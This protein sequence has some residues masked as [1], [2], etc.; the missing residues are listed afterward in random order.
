MS[1]SKNLYINFWIAKSKSRN[2]QCPIYA[3]ITI[4]G[5]RAELST[6]MIITEELWNA[7]SGRATG[8]SSLAKELNKRLA[9]IESRLYRCYDDLRYEGKFLSAPNL[10]SRYLGKDESEQTIKSIFAYHKVKMKGVLA[11]GT[12][13]N[14]GATENYVLNFLYKS[15]HIHNIELRALESRF[16]IDFEHFLHQQPSLTNNG[17]MKHLE[18]FKKLIKLAYELDWLDKNIFKHH[19]LKF[20]K[21]EKEFLTQV[22][23]QKIIDLKPKRNTLEITR[24]IFLFSCYTSLSYADVK[25]MRKSNIIYSSDGEKW[26][27]SK[28]AKTGIPLNIPL[29]P[30]P[31]KI[32]E[33]Y[34]NHPKVTDSDFL[35]P[36]YSNQK[37]NS[38]LREIALKAE[39]DKKFTFHTARHTFATTVTL[40]NGVPI[41]TVSKLLGHTKLA[42]TQIY[43]RVLK[44]KIAQDMKNLESR[45]K[46]N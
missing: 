38:Y 3:R 30:I 35:L 18:R 42:T 32:L 33:K 17:V 2:G 29:L 31:Q 20:K 25:D 6:Q 44:R 41:E 26:I 1:T 10:K 15:Q 28:R 9:Q 37:I 27:K 40:S 46:S 19:K 5:K 45:L 43:A 39:I 14:Y 36:V 21:V 13:K 11:Q 23:L 22:E 4:G 12:L 8:R 7:K 24:D 34:E 16:I